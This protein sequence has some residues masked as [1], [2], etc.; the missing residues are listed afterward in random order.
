MESIRPC[1]GPGAGGFTPVH[2]ARLCGPD[3]HFKLPHLWPVKLLQGGTSGL[4]VRVDLDGKFP[5]GFLEAVALAGELQQAMVTLRRLIDPV[6]D[7]VVFVRLEPRAAIHTLG[8]AV[9]PHDG[10]FFYQ[11]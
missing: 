5:C 1:H 9:E 11:G 8:V 4:S 7:R 10:E 3:G 2:P 6:D